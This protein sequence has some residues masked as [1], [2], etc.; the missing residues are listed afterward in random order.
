MESKLR[1]FAI[2]QTFGDSNHLHLQ[3][4]K[5]KV[6]HLSHEQMKDLRLLVVFKLVDVDSFCVGWTAKIHGVWTEGQSVDIHAP[7]TDEWLIK[8]HTSACT[9]TLQICEIGALQII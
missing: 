3:H 8:K 6:Q 7:V 4:S 2:C 1:Q 5:T 9:H